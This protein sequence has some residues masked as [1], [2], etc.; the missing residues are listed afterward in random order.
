MASPRHLSRIVLLVKST[1]NL[2]Y[3]RLEDLQPTSP[4]SSWPNLQLTEGP[5]RKVRY[6]HNRK[7]ERCK[8]W[9]IESRR[10]ACTGMEQG[11][12]HMRGS[13]LCISLTCPKWPACDADVILK[14][15]DTSFT[16]FLDGFAEFFW[17]GAYN[18]PI[19][20]RSSDVNLQG[21]P[22]QSPWKSFLLD[23]QQPR[24]R[25]SRAELLSPVECPCAKHASMHQQ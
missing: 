14:S 11:R 18:A 24:E 22:D 3:T 15:E 7:E 5:A 10:C 6:S 20:R 23:V 21:P 4:R 25:A 1:L 12:C 13:N 8:V 2:A 16:S 17:R 9:C 19:M